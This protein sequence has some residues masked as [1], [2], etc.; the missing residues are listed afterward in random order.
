MRGAS[1]CTKRDH[2]SISPLSPN[3]DEN[4]ISLYIITAFS[5][6]EVKQS[7]DWNKGN[8]HQG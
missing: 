5:N 4:E 6:N 7:S 3:S 2:V 1:V 8:N